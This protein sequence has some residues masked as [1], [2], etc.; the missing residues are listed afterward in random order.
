MPLHR[1]GA[2]R[3][4]ILV[5]LVWIA[6]LILP[7]A[8]ET[9]VALVVGNSD[10]GALGTLPNP[11]NDAA[12]MGKLLDEQLGFDVTVVTDA[13]FAAM[14]KAMTAFGRAAS[15]ADV[16][17]F[18]YA[19]HGVELEG[20]NYMLPVNADINSDVDLVSEG[21]RLDRVVDLMVQAGAKI[22]IVLVDACRN[23]PLPSVSTRGAR[24]L[25][26]LYATNID[27]LIAFATEPG[28]VAYDGDGSN[29]PF[30]EGL[31][32]YL[33]K[34]DLALDA[35]LRRVRNAVYSATHKKQFPWWDDM[36]LSDVYLGGRNATLSGTALPVASSLPAAD[37]IALCERIGTSTSP[38][39]LESYLDAYP[40]G[41]CAAAVRKRLALSGA[42]LGGEGKTPEKEAAVPP[43]PPPAPGS[44]V[45]TPTPSEEPAPAPEPA[46][47]VEQAAPAQTPEPEQVLDE[48]SQSKPA[49]QLT[50]T[51][52][53]YSISSYWNHNGSLVALSAQ[54][55]SRVFYYERPR[56]LME[57]AGVVKGT[58]LFKGQ[59]AG[60][61][62]KGQ[63]YQF[64][65]KCGPIAYP[66]KGEVSADFTR[67]DLSGE[68]PVRDSNCRRTGTKVDRLVFEYRSKSL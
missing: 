66:V 55:T 43:P 68:R 50:A 39:L 47:V 45:S 59:F 51:A 56:E 53:A 24:G 42:A 44:T 14:K 49:G 64:S 62:Y 67:I 46:A 7:A 34:P 3:R 8:A 20:A 37:D 10:Y 26:P 48:A 23:N 27:T 5:L 22:K 16:A 32:A 13:D 19:G 12:A 41:F 54:G 61:S 36:F 52:G 4:A 58:L 2:M 40:T 63:A 65:R 1:V 17:L 25:Q 33:G 9:R 11:K 57:K 18:Y 38:L 6:G 60:R 21:Y 30:T 31:I 28:H 15:N 35:T 29:S